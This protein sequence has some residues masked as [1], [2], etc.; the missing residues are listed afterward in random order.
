MEVVGGEGVGGGGRGG[1]GVRGGRGRSCGRRVGVTGGGSI[2]TRQK[3][4]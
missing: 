2:L 3:H 1:R 4:S